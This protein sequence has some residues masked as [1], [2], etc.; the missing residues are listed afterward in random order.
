MLC[1]PTGV[2]ARGEPT[3]GP[4]GVESQGAC[5]PSRR[6]VRG[7]AGGYHLVKPPQEISLGQVM[8]VIEGS[9]EE[10]GQTSSASP[11]SPAVKV[12]MHAWKEVNDVQRKML[13]AISLSDLL[14]RVKAQDDQMYHI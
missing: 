13:D 4:H 11:D 7:A 8:E 6:C 3:G 9:P 12:L 2:L 5:R 1:L 10:N 14:E